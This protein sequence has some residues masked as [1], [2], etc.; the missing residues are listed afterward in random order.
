MMKVE[1]NPIWK[2]LRFELGTEKFGVTSGYLY[3]RQVI[4]V[5]AAP[6]V[7]FFEHNIGTHT[8]GIVGTNLYCAGMMPGNEAFLV[9]GLGVLISPEHDDL[10][11]TRFAPY[12]IYEF[13]TENKRILCAP[14]LTLPVVRRTFEAKLDGTFFKAP[15]KPAS[16]LRSPRPWSDSSSIPKLFDPVV[17]LLPYRSFSLR[18][19]MRMTVPIEFVSPWH[20]TMFL[21]G[22]TVHGS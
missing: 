18:F 2:L 17:V 7:R 15:V 4:G 14:L 9:A 11:W 3:D 13:T 12:A 8:D 20:A 19:T 10:W 1:R 22:W 21:Q 16:P 5:V 6:H